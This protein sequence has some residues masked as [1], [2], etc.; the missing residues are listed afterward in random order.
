MQVSWRNSR[1]AAAIV[2]VVAALSSCSKAEHATAPA[3][4]HPARPAAHKGSGGSA[5]D[6]ADMVSAVS[7]GKTSTEIDLKFALRDRPVVGESVDIDIAVIPAHELDQVYATFNAADGLEIARGGRM[8][9]IQ[10]PEPGAPISHT[11]TIVP[12][13]DGIFFVSATVL[14]DSPTDSTTHSFSIP[15]IAGAG[16][17]PSAAASSSTPAPAAHPRGGSQ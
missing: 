4:A 5:L 15:V 11:V 13:R 17:A 14:A 2:I 9:Q 3:G 12:Q 8:P 7:A 16:F 6:L 1:L 10:H